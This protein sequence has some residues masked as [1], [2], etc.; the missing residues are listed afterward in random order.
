VL[1]VQMACLR[2]V[3]GARYSLIICLLTLHIIQTFVLSCGGDSAEVAELVRCG[4]RRA[5]EDSRSCRV[6]YEI[7][8][9]QSMRSAS[10][11]A[12]KCRTKRTAF[13]LR[14]MARQAKVWCVLKQSTEVQRLTS[15]FASANEGS[16]HAASSGWS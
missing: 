11:N 2:Q 9:C 15:I 6:R 5:H 8:K 1:L 16:S 7:G 10:I 3:S 13:V 4:G 14:G 12:H